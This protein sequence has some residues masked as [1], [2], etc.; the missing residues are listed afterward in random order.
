MCIRDRYM[1]RFRFVAFFISMGCAESRPSSGFTRLEDLEIRLRFHEHTV[2][3]FKQGFFKTSG[4]KLTLRQ[5]MRCLKTLNLDYM[6]DDKLL[7]DAF[8]DSFLLLKSDDMYDFN[9]TV[10]SMFLL[11][12]SAATDKAAALF[13][14]YDISDEGAMDESQLTMTFTRIS[15]AVF[16]YTEHILEIHQEVTEYHETQM[17]KKLDEALPEII[18]FFLGAEK[19]VDRENFISKFQSL[20]T[21]PSLIDFSSPNSIRAKLMDYLNHPLRSIKEMVPAEKTEKPTRISITPKMRISQGSNK[22]TSSNTNGFGK[23]ANRHL[24]TS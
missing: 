16:T 8:L 7:I 11:S 14:L 10:T 20:G 17:R 9:Q 23:N 12:K 22:D 2:E 15:E 21:Q 6:A 1:G 4:E 19:L 24:T 18:K 3:D 13:D 5:I